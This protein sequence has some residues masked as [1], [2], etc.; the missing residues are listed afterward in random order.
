MI[1]LVPYS[2]CVPVRWGRGGVVWFSLDLG[3]YH[4]QDIEERVFGRDE[5]GVHERHVSVSDKRM[6]QPSA[7]SFIGLYSFLFP[8]VEDE[9]DVVDRVRVD[10]EGVV[11]V[12]FE[13]CQR[14]KRIVRQKQRIGPADILSDTVPDRL[15]ILRGVG[16][17]RPHG[18]DRFLERLP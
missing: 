8:E 14:Q 17:C 7:D 15:D 18:F 6:D 5:R 2:R 3:L 16:A 10:R 9:I 1:V 11:P 13:R 12:D 4:L